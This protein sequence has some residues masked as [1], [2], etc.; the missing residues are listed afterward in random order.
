MYEAIFG[1]TESKPD[2]ETTD[3]DSENALKRINE[4]KDT[5]LWVKKITEHWDKKKLK[6][7]ELRVQNGIF[8]QMRAAREEE[9]EKEMPSK[10]RDQLL[11]EQKKRD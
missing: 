10:L 1:R 5:G 8:K 2:S 6:N 9:D 7:Y 4:I 3:T 11:R